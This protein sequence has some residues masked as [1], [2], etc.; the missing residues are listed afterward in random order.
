VPNSSLDTHD[1]CVDP[2]SFDID[3]TTGGNEMHFQGKF[4]TEREDEGT[5]RIYQDIFNSNNPS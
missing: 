3:Q 1:E 4:M 5:W 2:A